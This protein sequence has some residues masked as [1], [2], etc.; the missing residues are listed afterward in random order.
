MV[1]DI[2]DVAVALVMN[3]GL[4]GTARLQVAVTDEAHV[5]RLRR[6]AHLG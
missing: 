3:G 4:I 1:A 6:I 2:G 5:L